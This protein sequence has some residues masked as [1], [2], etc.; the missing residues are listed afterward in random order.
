MQITRI[1][2]PM[3]AIASPV[4]ELVKRFVPD[5][6]LKEM[7]KTHYFH[8][9]RDFRE[10]EEKDMAP[11]RYLVAAGDKAV[12]IGANIGIYTRLLSRLTG[13]GG[14]VISIEAVPS[15]FAILEQN[16][17]RLDLGNV[18]VLNYAVSES[19]GEVE[20]EIPGFRGFYRAKISDANAPSKSRGKRV[21]VRARKLDT[22]L[23]GESRP[24]AFVK[25]DVEGHELGCIRGATVLLEGHAPPWLME[26]GDDPDASDS[27][28][29][30]LLEIFRA[31][32]YDALWF[33]GGSLRKRKPGDASVNYFL[34][35]PQHLE[36][37]IARGL[38]YPVRD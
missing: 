3:L 26:I 4:K 14:E 21:K 10:E 7:K 35:K 34:L 8:V 31:R 28:G 2:A 13:L 32:G 1:G 36:C 38:P 5:S 23:A 17:R 27:K 22:L 20:M 16:V 37:M 25:C 6:V 15:T 19:D 11:V 9:L 18:R 12:D 30:Q 29:R 33:D 24:I